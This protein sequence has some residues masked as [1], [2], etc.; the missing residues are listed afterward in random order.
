MIKWNV[1]TTDKYILVEWESDEK[2]P[3]DRVTEFMK[4]FMK[5]APLLT[6]WK[7]DGR[8]VCIKGEG[9]PV[10]HA[11]LVYKYAIQWGTNVAGLGEIP[12]AVYDKDVGACVVVRPLR[13]K[14]GHFPFGSVV[15][16]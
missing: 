6:I 15:K 3:A 10:L 16:V 7:V 9:S 14:R 13:T 2:I 8:L 12:V 1:T 4:E 5:S 11:A